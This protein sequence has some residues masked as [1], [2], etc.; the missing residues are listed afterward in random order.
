MVCLIKKPALKVA[1]LTKAQQKI[2]ASFNASQ[3]YQVATFVLKQTDTQTTDI[4][5]VELL[6]WISD[7]SSQV[8]LIPCFAVDQQRFFRVYFF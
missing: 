4:R 3:S 6:Q 5:H 8:G 1:S 2:S 7:F